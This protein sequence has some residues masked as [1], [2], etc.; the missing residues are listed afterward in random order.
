MTEQ[1]SIM[2]DIF[3]ELDTQLNYPQLYQ[4]NSLEISV[5]LY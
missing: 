1:L 4:P 5:I 3:R 2:W